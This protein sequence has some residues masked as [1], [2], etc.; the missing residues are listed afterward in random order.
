MFCFYP[1]IEDT[2]DLRPNTYVCLVCTSMLPVTNRRAVESAILRQA[3][4]KK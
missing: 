1:V 3:R 2:G 4:S